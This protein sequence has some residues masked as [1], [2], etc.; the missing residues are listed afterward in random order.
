L[1]A[2]Q[3]ENR[4]RLTNTPESP[5]AAPPARR[6]S[7]I[8]QVARFVI[9]LGAVAAA[10]WALSGKTDELQGITGYLDQLRWWWMAVAVG[11]EGASYLA[12]ST[13][14]RQLLQAGDVRIAAVPMLG[15]S[16]AGSAIQYSLPGGSVFYLAYSFRQYRRRGADDVLAG[17][18]IVAFNAVT[19]VALAAIAAVGLALAV[20]AGSTYNLVGVI[21]GIVFVA[22]L[23][24][25]AWAERARLLPHLTTAVRL[26][27]KLFHH[28]DHQVPAAEVVQ[29]WMTEVGSISPSRRD[30]TRAGVMGMSNW[31]ADMGCLA[32]SFMAVGAP[33][34]WRGLLLAY[35][36]GQ[37]AA[38]LP[39]TPGGLGVVEGSL[40]VALVTFGGGQY[41]TVAAVLLYRLVSFWLVLPVGWLSWATLAMAGRSRTRDLKAALA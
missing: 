37:L 24:V 23:V 27:Q 8:W 35:G 29:R 19:F 30:W 14:Q 20:S 4:G 2:V 22:A 32:L 38:N 6:R 1:V 41:S 31:L 17:W 28:P 11:A 26:S 36:A 18:T 21:L 12:F 16:L 15:I 13:L 5:F 33:V 10:A 34:P 9:G 3:R 39:V 7:R 25:G 40:T